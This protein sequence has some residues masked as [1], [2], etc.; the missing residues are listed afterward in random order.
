MYEIRK[1]VILNKV[2]QMLKDEY[3]MYSH[4]SEYK[5]LIK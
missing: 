5:L 1:K 3:G 4:I 2:T